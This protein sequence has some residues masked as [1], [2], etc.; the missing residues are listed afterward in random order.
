MA[1]NESDDLL[2]HSLCTIKPIE[3]ESFTDQDLRN[4][5]ESVNDTT[6]ARDTKLQDQWRDEY[7]TAPDQFLELWDGRDDGAHKNA[8]YEVY[9]ITGSGEQKC[10]PVAKHKENGEDS[11][12][13]L[14]VKSVWDTLKEVNKN[15]EAVGRIII[16]QEV[17]P[18]VLGAVH[19]TLKKHFDMDELLQ[20]LIYK[21]GNNGM[22]KA[23]MDRS[24][25][26]T[27]L[28]QRTF[29]FVFKYYTVVNEN[30]CTP[31]PWQ[32]HDRRPAD[33]KC[34]DHVD[35][36]ECSSILA[37]SLG[38]D[39]IK[40]YRAK[41]KKRDTKDHVVFDTSA[42]WQL[43]SIQC[44]P[45][46]EHTMRTS[47]GLK[48]PFCNGPF[49]FLDSL[50]LEYHDAVTRYSQINDEVTKLITPPSDF[51]FNSELR[52]GLLFEDEDFSYSRRYFWAY[53]TLG[54]IN[55]G[56]DSMIS[57]YQETFTN[58]F[59]K[60]K[61]V[62]LWAHPDPDSSDGEAYAKCMGVL[63]HELDR[64]VN[65]LEKVREKNK[66]T[67]DEI[68]SLR[69]QLFSG[70]SVKESRRAIEQGDNIKILTV[71]S[72]LFLPL[73]FVTVSQESASPILF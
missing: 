40:R 67:Q 65:N 31:A 29:F 32:S 21:D 64:E 73:T 68:A 16:L 11:Q 33:R 69:D 35:I 43:L 36:A 63:R 6:W 26:S 59:W 70:S 62:K 13:S 71:V 52:D 44:F 39:P 2:S 5:L 56:I 28:R 58:D 60:G 34:P 45:D 72:M 55:V 49:A 42:P 51:M 61:L 24:T 50:A 7:I 20:H 14:S 25:E 12:Q 9:E 27:P 30:K 17:P 3:Q 22:T 1:D 8:T 18:L 54:V 15:G 38:G 57:A 19:M 4:H 66:K 23:Y 10:I 47:E 46:D 48:R 37:L 53:N 41:V